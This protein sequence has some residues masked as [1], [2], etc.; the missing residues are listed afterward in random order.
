M[1]QKTSVVRELTISFAFLQPAT[2]YI[3]DVELVQVTE[4]SFNRFAKLPICFTG[5]D[6]LTI[7]ILDEATVVL[8]PVSTLPLVHASMDVWW[9]LNGHV[10]LH[11][12]K[13]L[14]LSNNFSHHWINYI[15]VH[16]IIITIKELVKVLHQY[17]VNNLL[18]KLENE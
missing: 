2:I 1:Q 17:L 18:P 4:A 11:L 5:T 10:L 6:F 9:C 15:E 16:K 3:E 14:D 13:I 12:V 7:S 8:L